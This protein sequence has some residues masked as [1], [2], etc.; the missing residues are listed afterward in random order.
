MNRLITSIETESMIYEFP[1]HKSPGSD[2]FTGKFC[3]TFREE[4]TPTLSKLFQ[5]KKKKQSKEHL[6]THSM[7]PPSP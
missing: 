2:G 5:E 1:Q 4:L 3:Q 6:Q 7:K